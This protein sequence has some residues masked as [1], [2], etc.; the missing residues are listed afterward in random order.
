LVRRLVTLLLLA[1]IGYLVYANRHHISFMAGLDSNKIRISG[2][3]YEV[4]SDFKEP[5]VYEFSE[6]IILR[7]GDNSYGSYYFTSWAEVVVTVDRG[8]ITYTIS[9]PDEETMEW[10]QEIKGEMKLVKKWAR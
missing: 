1:V 9:F 3:W 2:E 5:D 6:G 8:P 10:R 4:V 7:E